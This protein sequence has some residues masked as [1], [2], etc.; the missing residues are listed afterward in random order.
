MSGAQVPYLVVGHITVDHTPNGREWGGT[1]LF[2]AI[3]ALRLGAKVHVLTSIPDGEI[4]KVLP[5]DVDVTNV[6]SPDWC[7]FRHEFVGDVREQYI[8]NVAC[9]LRAEHVPK[10]WRTLPLVH[11]GPL[12]QEIDHDLLAAFQGSLRGASVQGWL[13]KWGE[14]GHVHP[15][16]PDQMLAWAPPIEVSFLSEEDIGDQR[17]II[18]LYRKTHRIVV[19]TDGRHGA[20]LFEGENATRIPAFPVHEVDANG[21]GDVFS[22][23][24]M[25]RYYE[26]GRA[27]ES[28]RFAAVVASFHVEQHGTD[29]IPTRDQAERRLLE[30]AHI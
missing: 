6:P 29:G 20:T 1:A 21:A 12:V 8:T 13:R 7:T 15:L 24:F 9:T 18:D 30:Y 19:L 27:V 25:V 22:A 17:A 5:P 26:T 28:A 14:D 11:F 3:T 16:D 10:H 2:G 23:A 4:S